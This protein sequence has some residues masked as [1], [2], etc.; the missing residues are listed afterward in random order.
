MQTRLLMTLSALTLGA[1]GVAASFLPDELLTLLHGTA[2]G[3]L[4]LVVQLLGACYVAL[5]MLNW[6]AR[7]QL[8]G[9]IY[10]RPVAVANFTHFM[11][12]G[13]ALLKW[14]PG[15]SGAPLLWL[16]SLVALLFAIWF[17]LVLFR[18]PASAPA[19]PRSPRP[20]HRH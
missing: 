8:I 13:L 12:A 18:S 2:P 20:R 6:M 14:L 17:G 9:G 4:P 5:A 15:S 1:A 11:I 3:T 10:S 7:E 16:V 19:A